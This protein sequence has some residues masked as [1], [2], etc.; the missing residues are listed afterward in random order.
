MPT[1]DSADEA[2]SVARLISSG[3]ISGDAKTTALQALRDFD[4][5]AAAPVTQGTAAPSDDGL[6]RKIALGGRA[7]GEGVAGTLAL[8]ANLGPM[9]RNGMS[10]GVNAMFGT[11]LQTDEPTFS[12]GLSKALTDS[13]AYTP[14]TP[15]E[16]MGSA[17]TQGVAGAL[18]G[19]G[20]LGMA[21][22]AAS[23][24]PNLI[25]AGLAGATGAGSSEYAAQNGAGPL[26]QFAAGA[27]GALAPGGIE[28][29]TRGALR[30]VTGGVRT[31][32]NSGT[33]AGAQ[34]NATVT[35]GAAQATNT[36]TGAA[37]ATGTGGGSVLG[38]VGPDPSAGLTGAQQTALAQG[39]ALGFRT[40]PGQ[41]LGSRSLQQLEARAESQPLFSG[42][43]NTLK[44]SNQEAL[45]TAVAGAIGETGNAVDSSV[46]ARANDRL[47]GVFENVRSPTRITVLDPAATKTALDQIDSD[48]EGLL[49]G[50]S[51]IR[52]NKLVQGLEKLTAT[53]G[54][55]GQQLGTLSS[56]LGKA[57]YK[58]MTSPSGD[59]DLGHALYQVKDHVDDIVQSGLDQTEQAAYAAARRQYRNL[60]QITSRVGV[61]NPSTGNVSG[62]ALANMLQQSDKNGFLMGRNQTPMYNAARFAQAFK[63]IVGD[64]GTATRTM[65]LSPVNF[66]L[67]LPFS[68]VSRAYLS[69]PGASAVGAARAAAR[70]SSSTVKQAAG[71]GTGP[72]ANPFNFNSLLVPTNQQ[73]Q[74][75]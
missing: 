41:A 16:K 18:T 51:S 20:L 54:A 31:V 10:R 65:D 37:N 4:T 6:L 43:F 8:P 23:S 39:T 47:A 13:G 33:G 34:A 24:A 75:R 40:T 61:V 9:I 42:P 17:I 57:A 53:G 69:S 50:D 44:R 46:L 36:V 73:G 38:R 67:S 29:M 14:D 45:N 22:P 11:H 64:S 7:I 74:Q 27:V 19:G 3:Q 25:R 1:I 32:A 30:S 35:P 56:K 12:Q 66:A 5:K 58:Q 28:A 59:R 2:Q 21:A 70:A 71:I 63:P 55:N 26:G 62:G 48:A 49:P 72:L 52:D 60:M 68:A 15:G